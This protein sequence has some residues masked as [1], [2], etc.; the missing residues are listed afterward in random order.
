MA[1]RGRLAHLGGLLGAHGDG[2]LHVLGAL[3]APGQDAGAAQGHQAQQVL[4]AGQAAAETGRSSRERG[5]SGEDG[6][7]WRW[8][9]AQRVPAEGVDA[10]G[11]ATAGQAVGSQLARLAAVGKQQQGLPG[12]ALKELA[13]QAVV[14]AGQEGEG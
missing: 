14:A 7:L 8:S 9:G 1:A 2:Q 6:A 12:R 13:L 3:G 11:C 10:A 4:T 5:W